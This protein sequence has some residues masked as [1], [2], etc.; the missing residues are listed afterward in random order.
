MSQLSWEL[1]KHSRLHRTALKSVAVDHWCS[2]SRRDAL[3]S[4]GGRSNAMTL[5]FRGISRSSWVTTDMNTVINNGVWFGVFLPIG[6]DNYS[7]QVIGINMEHQHFNRCCE[8]RA[9]KRWTKFLMQSA[10]P[11][12]SLNSGCCRSVC[13]ISKPFVIVKAL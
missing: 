9:G 2:S 13:E 4:E 1:S 8:I 6:V 11:T 3:L 10:L 12:L 7:S 5:L